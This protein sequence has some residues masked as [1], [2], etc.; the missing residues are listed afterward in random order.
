MINN[1]ELWGTNNQATEKAKRAKKNA[2]RHTKD[3]CLPPR[4]KKSKA[5]GSCSAAPL[6]R[7]EEGGSQGT[8]HLFDMIQKE[9]VSILARALHRL[10]WNVHQL[11]HNSEAWLATQLI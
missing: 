7:P 3:S 5:S 11:D 4:H 2:K 6:P 1:A 9:E 10:N 8:K